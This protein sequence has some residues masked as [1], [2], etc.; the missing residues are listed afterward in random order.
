MH[1]KKF[2]GN[3]LFLISLFCICVFVVL[4]LFCAFSFNKEANAA[5]KTKIDFSQSNPELIAVNAPIV[6]GQYKVSS[7]ASWSRV[8]DVPGASI[9]SSVQMQVYQ[10][11]GSAAQIFDL[12]VDDKGYYTILNKNSGLALDVR[13]AVASNLTPVQQYTPNGSSAQK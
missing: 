8:I 2:M 5:E 9:A 10:H 6:Q 11:N 12:K 3:R 13:G 1:K 4:A 7:S